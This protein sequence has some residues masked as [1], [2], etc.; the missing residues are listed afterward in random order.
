MFDMYKRAAAGI[1]TPIAN[2]VKF[3]FDTDGKPKYK[4]ETGTV[5]T[6]GGV[7]IKDEGVLALSTDTLNLIGPRIKATSNAGVADITVSSKFQGI[8]DVTEYGAKGNNT[9]DDT[10]AINAAIAAAVAYQ[11]GTDGTA[12]QRGATVYF[13]A[14][15][16]KIT[17]ALTSPNADGISFKGDGIGAST[18]TVGFVAGD[19]LAF[20]AGRSFQRVSDLQFFATVT[21]TS[22][23]FINTNGANDV[24]LEKFSMNGA[25]IGVYVSNSSI[26]VTIQDY[27]INSCVATTG[28]GIWVV[29]GLAGDT[30]ITGKGVFSNSAGARPL[31]SIR[32]QQ[33]GHFF[34]GGANCTSAL[35]GLLIDPGATQDVSYGFITDSLFDSVGTTAMTINP[36]NVATARVRSIKFTNTWFAGAG[37]SAGALITSQGS[38]AIVD[39][40]E[41][42]NCR[43]LNNATHGLSVQFGTNIKVV[44][45]NS[46]GNSVAASNT[47]DGIN[48]GP[49]VTSISI[50][51]LRSG[52]AGTAGSSHRYGIAIGAMSSSSYMMITDCDLTGNVTG[53]Y[54]STAGSLQS[55]VNGNIGMPLAPAATA[56][57]SLLATAATAV[58]CTNPMIVPANSLRVGQS[59]RWTLDFT[60]AATASTQTIQLKFGTAGSIA[61]TSV[62]SQALGAGTAAA[63]S[64]TV[65][66][67]ATVKSIGATTAGFYVRVI[68]TQNGATGFT[69]AASQQFVGALQTLNST[70]TNS[71]GIAVSPSAANTVTLQTTRVEVLSQ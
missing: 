25:F 38:A 6:I 43:F 55:V 64:A 65:V 39:D 20:T 49:N 30:Y 53:P 42:H 70:V 37:T 2:K 12:G 60:N 4:D 18:I 26:K 52:P 14:G 21:R 67:E 16:Y 1:L 3:F 62:I 19:V 24:L 10:S 48:V 71:M 59:F 31:A 44:G 63:G 36:A 66:V 47:S 61:D 33:S 51:G 40:L 9:N 7:A 68:C 5:N 22:G 35:N 23:A 50:I 34:I 17:A 15:I 58:Y 8:F 27:T 56:P 54:L 57:G 32:I 45:G 13:P 46:S 28:I 69:N 41:F 11:S 29:N